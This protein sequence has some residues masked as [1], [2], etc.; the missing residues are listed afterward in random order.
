[1][2]PVQRFNIGRFI[3]WKR[4]KIKMTAPNQATS[5]LEQVLKLPRTYKMIIPTDYLDAN[6]HMNVMYYTDVG[7]QALIYFFRETGLNNG[8]DRQGA[9][10][11]TRGMFAL[12]QVL[13]YMNELRAGEEVAVHSGIVGY[14]SKRVHFMHYIV[15]LTHN[16]VASSDE[17]VAIYIDLTVRRSTS[18]EP[19]LL[20][21]LE[22]FKA[23]YAN[24]GWQ[25]EVSG[26]I[27]LK[28]F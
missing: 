8:M 17:R 22:K 7:N 16:R 1:M 4:K 23:K 6:G 15:S 9:E 20:S 14:D 2:R 26:A 25:P 5:L 10:T 24:L 28:P 21:N 19:E 27:Q 18:F 3:A 11:R 13:T 12:R